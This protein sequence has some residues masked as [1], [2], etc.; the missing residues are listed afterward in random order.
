MANKLTTTNVRQRKDGRWEGR[1]RA[2]GKQRAVYG[3]TKKEARDKLTEKLAEIESGEFMEETNMT[4]E[5]WMNEYLSSYVMDL[6]ESTM[7]N[8]EIS[9]R[10][11]I[12]PGLGRIKLKELAPVQVQR[13][14]RSL[15]GK[16]LSAKTIH[17]VHGILHEGLDKA[18]KMGFLKK[19]VTD[20]CDLPKVRKVEMHPLSSKQLREFMER[21]D[22]DPFYKPIFHIA[23]FTGMR[24]AEI[25]GLT[26]D[27]I[28][29]ETNTIRVYRQYVRL[30]YGPR[31]GQYD[32]TPLKNGKERSFRVAS[33][34]M[35][36][37]R[38]LKQRQAEQKLKAGS[39]FQNKRNFVMT[40]ED[41]RP[42]SASTMY[43]HYKEIVEAMGLPD[44]RFHDARHT[45]ATLALQNHVD[46]KTLSMAL[47]H[48]TVAFTLDIY[49]HVSDE[50]Q[51]DMAE[52]MERFIAQM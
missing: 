24:E 31:K 29:F 14:Y 25:V 22:E 10:R 23:F 37:F 8:Y 13:F 52:K 27:C 4:V 46:P 39:S 9:I 21:A 48:A 11:H 28:N 49:G 32:F 43:H 44:V 15:I 51:L 26:W 42:I 12:V 50:M 3:K 47:G 2:E 36:T 41:G 38:Y 45:Y 34:V 6:K 7:S 5:Q 40:R 30:D 35:Q 33:S 17:N 18:V 16:G 1:Y 20:L 19:N